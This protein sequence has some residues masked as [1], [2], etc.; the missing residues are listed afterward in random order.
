MNRYVTA[1][2]IGIPGYVVV[3]FATHWYVALALVAI[4]TANNMERRL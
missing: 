3:G 2:A 1:A 4:I